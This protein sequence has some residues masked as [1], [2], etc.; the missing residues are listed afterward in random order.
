MEHS[1]D[2]ADAFR[3]AE[4][5]E[6]ENL[7]GSLINA[8]L[9]HGDN[10]LDSVNSDDLIEAMNKSGK[11][12]DEIAREFNVLYKHRINVPLPDMDSIYNASLRTSTRQLN[13]AEN[14][15]DLGIYNDI[16]EF[17]NLLGDFK[18]N[19]KRSISKN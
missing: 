18:K 5:L 16:K 7:N 6:K 17:R 3:T 19:R 11:S 4:K 10:L 9:E 1:D 2:M 8:L 15:A 13:T 12:P 14:A